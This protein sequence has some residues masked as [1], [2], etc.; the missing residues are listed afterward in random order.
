MFPVQF[1]FRVVERISRPGE[2][3][4]DPFA[5]RGTSVFAGQALDRRTTGIEINPVGWLYS[6]VKLKPASRDSV[7]DRLY[8][9][10]RHSE[11]IDERWANL[12]VFFRRC[13]SVNV[14]RFLIAARKELKWET[15]R[16]DATLAVFI[17]LYLHGK[18]GSCLSNQMRDGKAMAP[19]YA[20]KWWREHHLSPPK[21]NPVE[22]LSARIK[23]RYKLGTPAYDPSTAILGDSTQIMS[24]FA[25]EVGRGKRKPFDA[26]FTS[27]PYCG[28]T[29]YHYDQWLRLWFLGGSD[30]PGGIGTPYRGK[31]ESREEYSSLIESVFSH[32]ASASRRLANW[33][34]RTDARTFTLDT[35][36]DVLRH[37]YPRRQLRMIRR[38][39]RRSTQ[40]ALYGDDTQKPGEVDLL[41]GDHY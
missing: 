23:W 18:R 16:T 22:F 2:S 13:Y 33:Y 38:P 8:V 21:V 3:I 36:V 28:V 34:V 12:P 17:M 1:A 15:D 5:G 25:R 37:L 20:V 14:L 24:R 35:T 11:R 7:L 40:T 29:N 27:P 6:R 30:T 32:A 41:L 31:F 4:I 39:Y 9:I 10:G 19:G 26:V